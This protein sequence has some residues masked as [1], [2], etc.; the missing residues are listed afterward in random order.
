MPSV[1]KSVKIEKPPGEAFALATDPARFE[2]WLTLHA[3]WPD[4][5]PASVDQGATFKQKLTIMGMPADVDW[6]VEEKSDSKVV[7]RGG[8]PMGAQLATTITA[9]PDG[10]ATM[11]SYEADFSGGG[12]QGPMGDMVAQKAGDE[13]AASLEKLKELA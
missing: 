1:S 7:M 5:P 2:E 12:I 6:T 11:V 9:V 3:A 13:I 10:E 8:G 4:G